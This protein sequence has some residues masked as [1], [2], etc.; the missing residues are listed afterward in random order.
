MAKTEKEYL[1]LLAKAKRVIKEQEE[2][3]DQLRGQVDWAIRLLDHGQEIM[4]D[5]QE[6]N[7]RLID[8]LKLKEA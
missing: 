5:Q 2:I 7:K 4:K 6:T 8:L 3:I 1:E